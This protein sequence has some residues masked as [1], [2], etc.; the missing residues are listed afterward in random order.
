METQYVKDGGAPKLFRK[1]TKTL[2]KSTTR[3]YLS[4]NTLGNRRRETA[5]RNK[6][7]RLSGPGQRRRPAT[8]GVK[9]EEKVGAD[10]KTRTSETR[11]VPKIRRAPTKAAT[12]R[13]TKLRTRNENSF[14]GQ[15]R[16]IDLS[17]L[18]NPAVRVWCHHVRR[19][20]RH[21]VDQLEA[22]EERHPLLMR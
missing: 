22:Q 9:Q 12:R 5:T 4:R 11:A 17:K 21:E 14:V 19:R 2:P 1:P 13:R 3:D 20:L 18:L 6:Q 10:K 15:V 7:P 8:N 16:N